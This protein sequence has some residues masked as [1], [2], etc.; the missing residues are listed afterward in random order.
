MLLGLALLAVAGGTQAPA[1]E[2]PLKIG[3][4]QTFF[5]DMSDKMIKSYS[6]PFVD[7]LRD[8]TGLTG[9]LVRGGEPLGVAKQLVDQKLQLAVFHGAEFG[10]VQQKYPELRPLMVA[11]NSAH[12]V[13]AYV[14]VRKEGGPASFADLKGKDVALPER[15]SDPC[16]LFLERECRRA[17]AKGSKDFFGQ[18]V[19]ADNV[20]SALDQ[21]SQG[22]FQAAVTDAIG[23]TFYKELKPGVFNRLKV[24]AESEIFP[25]VVVAYR[26]GT[27]SDKTLESLRRGLATAHKTEM[28]QDMMKT[29]RITSFA[30]VPGNFAKQLEATLKAY[31][32]PEEKK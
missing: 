1:G 3:M 22:K 14:L 29:W 13:R 32:G 26:P 27:L 15:T 7:V 2:S 17:G 8:S 6:E 30:A 16:R 12:E 21:L 5:H 20:E 25:P 10:W 24:L 28:G 18:V 11:V 31:P 9:Q 23:L 4:P 19:R